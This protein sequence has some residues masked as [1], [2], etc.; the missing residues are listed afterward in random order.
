MIF[1]ISVDGNLDLKEKY[2]FPKQSMLDHSYPN[3][4]NAKIQIT[5]SLLSFSTFELSIIDLKGAK[6]NT[7]HKGKNQRAC[8]N[9]LGMEEMERKLCCVGIYFVLFADRK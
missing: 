7:L 8:I 5:L 4:F 2:I 6:V 3:P 1:D 9:L